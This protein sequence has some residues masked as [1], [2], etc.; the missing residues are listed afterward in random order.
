LGYIYDDP[1]T[2]SGTAATFTDNLGTAAITGASI[3]ITLTQSGSGTPSSLNVRPIT[4]LTGLSVY[5]D[6]K[7]TETIVWTQLAA[8]DVSKWTTLRSTLSFV[9]TKTT[10]I[11]TTSSSIKQ[12]AIDLT[13][14]HIYLVSGK[15]LMSESNR[16]LVAGFYYG[17]L[18]TNTYD[19]RE[20][21]TYEYGANDIS[22]SMVIDVQ[23]DDQQ[24]RFGLATAATPSEYATVENL[25]IYDLTNIFHYS[26]DIAAV[27]Y[28][29]E[30]ETS[31]AGLA[32][33]RSHYFPKSYY[34]YN[35]GEETCMSAVNGDPYS[36]VTLDWTSV[37]DVVYGGTVNPITGLLTVTKVGV[38]LSTLSWNTIATGSTNKSLSTSVSASYPSAN[39][40]FV[41][42][43]YTYIGLSSAGSLGSP[44][45]NSVGLYAY[46]ATQGAA[47]S[48]YLVCPVAESPAGMLVYTLK[49]P[50]TYMLTPQQIGT[51]V[52]TNKVWSSNW[53]YLSV[54]VS[55]VLQGFQGWLIKVGPNMTLVPTT[56]IQAE[57]YK[58]T[59]DQRMEETAERDS[60][61]Q[62]WR[63]TVSNTPPK[64]EFET[65]PCYN[66]DVSALNV[67]F[68]SAFSNILERKLTVAFYDPEEDCYKTWE[69]YMPDA[70]YPIRTI[71]VVNKTIFYD[72]IRF[73]FIGY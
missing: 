28:D 59:P 41:A 65:P 16:T 58:V 29:T 39:P 4:G 35:G 73:A 56:M 47:T 26:P 71:D 67:I 55:D 69:C 43:N 31:G 64:I 8:L 57:T 1:H 5:N 3:P 14:N 27:I 51:L 10:M 18:G 62:L 60:T 7:F 68:R 11:P 61:G 70:Q 21:F 13:K 42:S 50:I 6:P 32:Y 38:D 46:N 34:P 66:S 48:V 20:T 22:F 44:D 63:E 24:F 19:Y 36:L 72:P 2:Y 17:N 9:G 25:Q 52:G 54:T 30:T 12:A 40:G 45:N 53:A 23:R 37:A 49:T 15:Y 33:F